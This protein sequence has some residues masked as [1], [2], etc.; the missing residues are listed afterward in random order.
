[1]VYD[2]DGEFD[3]LISNKGQGVLG[4]GLVRLYEEDG[5]EDCPRSNTGRGV[6]GSGLIRRKTR[7]SSLP[8]ELQRAVL[9]IGLI[10]AN[11]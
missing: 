1:M 4:N 5:R 3:R 11:G 8:E 7:R 6:F 10:T 2:E 9:G